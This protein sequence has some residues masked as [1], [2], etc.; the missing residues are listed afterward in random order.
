[1][2]KP[3]SLCLHRNPFENHSIDFRKCKV[4]YHSNKAQKQPKK[5]T[6]IN[7]TKTQHKDIIKARWGLMYPSSLVKNDI[8]EL[9]YVPFVKIWSITIAS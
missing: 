4:T 9:F 6:I 7:E 2:S 8:T 3:F 5:H 1:M